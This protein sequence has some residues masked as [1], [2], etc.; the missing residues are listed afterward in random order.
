MRFM[1]LKKALFTGISYRL[2]LK[3][4]PQNAQAGG[5]FSGCREKVK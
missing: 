2:S 5:E 4:P 3:V 1:R